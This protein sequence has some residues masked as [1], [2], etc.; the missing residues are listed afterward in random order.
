MSFG[1]GPQRNNGAEG[2]RAIEVYRCVMGRG[3]H[4][5]LTNPLLGKQTFMPSLG[6][7]HTNSRVSIYC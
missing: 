1:R 4:V 3:A 5:P 2:E 6:I 7:E